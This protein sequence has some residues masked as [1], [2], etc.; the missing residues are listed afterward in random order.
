MLIE[1]KSKKVD[2]YE[3]RFGVVALEKGF[4]TAD[5]LVNALTIQVQE[6]IEVG[7]HRFIVKIFVDQGIMSG[8]QVSETLKEILL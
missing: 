2:H 3:K 1:L 4:I 7:Y 8:N 5:E 6:D